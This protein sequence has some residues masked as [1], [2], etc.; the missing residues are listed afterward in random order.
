MP[1]KFS[2]PKYEQERRG[3]DCLKREVLR[4]LKENGPLDSNILYV[5]FEREPFWRNSNGS[6]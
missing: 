6:Q 1:K 2:G 3:V 4:Y 5:H